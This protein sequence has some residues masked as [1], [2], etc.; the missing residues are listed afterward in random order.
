MDG[1]IIPFASIVS[2]AS[3]A[4]STIFGDA[5]LSRCF[6]GSQPSLILILCCVKVV[7]GWSSVSS[8]MYRATSWSSLFFWV[9]SSVDILAH[10]GL[11]S[12]STRTLFS[13]KVVSG[14]RLVSSSLYRATSWSSTSLWVGSSAEMFAH[15]AKIA[16]AVPTFVGLI[17]SCQIPC[18]T[19]HQPW[20]NRTSILKVLQKSMPSI[21][22]WSKPS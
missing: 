5:L 11:Q 1:S 22:S 19:L 8:G 7:T 17:N 20:S 16:G 12:L 2:T 14:C 3:L 18:L 15:S 10:S 21:A 4:I 6:T 9:G 13:S